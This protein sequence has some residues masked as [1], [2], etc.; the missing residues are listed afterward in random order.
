MTM[1][2]FVGHSN[3]S[4]PEGEKLNDYK[5]KRGSDMCNIHILK[6]HILKVTLKEVQRS[7]KFRRKKELQLLTNF[8]T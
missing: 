4:P 7:L 3:S 2:Y 5:N 8:H 1:K 6:I